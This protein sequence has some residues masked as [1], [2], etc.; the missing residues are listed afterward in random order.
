MKISLFPLLL[1]LPASFLAAEDFMS[2]A[3]PPEL[4]ENL[5]SYRT[6]QQKTEKRQRAEQ[7]ARSR[8]RKQTPAEKTGKGTA[9]E[10]PDAPPLKE[11]YLSYK[12]VPNKKV[13]VYKHGETLIRLVD[14]HNRP[15]PV[16]RVQVEKSG[17]QVFGSKDGTVKITYHGN[18]IPSAKL[19]VT[20]KGDL[21]KPLIFV[22][23]YNEYRQELRSIEEVKI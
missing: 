17:F 12:Y 20:R 18:G 6:A 5:T 13:F 22:L 8:D 9:S 3:P 15:V 16:A 14:S 2:P 19:K 4:G 1:L 10:A 11:L 23:K 21:D 7:E